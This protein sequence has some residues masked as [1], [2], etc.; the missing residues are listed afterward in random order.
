MLD[1]P[2]IITTLRKANP[3]LVFNLEM[4]T[5]DPLRIPSLTE[6]FFATF[7]ERKAT[8][9]E[10]AMER[11]MANPLKGLPPGVKGKPID[12]VLAEEEGSNRHG[13]DWM[14]KNIPA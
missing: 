14:Q 10:A 5:R 9:L 1:L 8:H 6:G 11:V 2:R 13:L 4:A 7:P 12:E 3:S